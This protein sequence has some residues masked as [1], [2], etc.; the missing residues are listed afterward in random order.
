MTVE[1]SIERLDIVVQTGHSYV[2]RLMQDLK[3]LRQSI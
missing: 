2:F 1:E 3:G